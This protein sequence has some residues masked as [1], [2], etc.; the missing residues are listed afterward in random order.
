MAEMKIIDRT[1]WDR[2]VLIC[3]NH[4]DNDHVMKITEPNRETFYAKRSKA[5]AANSAFYACTEFRS[6]FGADHTKKSCNNRLSIDM[7]T[8]FIEKLLQERM[9]DEDEILYENNLVGWKFNDTYGGQHV[10]YEV[11]KEE[12]GRY[13]V[14]MYNHSAVGR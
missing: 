4:E 10:T 14:R 12:K 9:G 2:I 3:G 1:I 13:Y 8:R 7:M 5:R 11:V 6:I